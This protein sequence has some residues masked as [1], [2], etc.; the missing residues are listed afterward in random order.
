MIIEDSNCGLDD[1]CFVQFTLGPTANRPTHVDLVEMSSED[2]AAH[3]T[4][5][6]VEVRV[7]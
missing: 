2:A 5:V 7:R 1:Y 6:F 4:T 3:A